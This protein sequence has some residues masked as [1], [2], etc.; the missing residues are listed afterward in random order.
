MLRATERGL[1]L[2]DFEVMTIGMIIDYIITY[3]NEHLDDEDRIDEIK[4]ATQSDY[5]AF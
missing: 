2:G 4:V 5:D 1:Y 3:N